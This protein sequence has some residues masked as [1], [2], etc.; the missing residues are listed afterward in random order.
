MLYRSLVSA[1]E[2][3]AGGVRRIG[4]DG[5]EGVGEVLAKQIKACGQSMRPWRKVA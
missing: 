5:F 2:D 4:R 3:R 1:G